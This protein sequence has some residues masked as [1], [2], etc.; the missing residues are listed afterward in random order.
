MT[1]Y[2]LGYLILL[3][4]VAFFAC[5][6]LYNCPLGWESFE[7]HCYRFEFGEPHSYQ[8]AN[9]ACWVKGS[10]L[11]SVN[12]RLEFEFVGSWLLRHDIYK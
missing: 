4:K 2:A 10:A 1:Q 11:V 6:K 9:S 3:V 12:T 8:D 5:Q 7:N